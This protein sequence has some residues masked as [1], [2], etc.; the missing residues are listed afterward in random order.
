MEKLF[1]GRI[2]CI[3]FTLCEHY[4]IM[5]IFS[6]FDGMSCLQ[7]AL[8]RSGIEYDNYF[9]SETD[10][11]AIQITQKNYPLTVQL[12]D[13]SKIKGSDMPKIDLMVGGSPCQGFSFAGKHLNFNDPRSKLIFEF[14]RLYEEL[15]EINPGLKFILE[16]VRMKKEHQNVITNFF[17]IDPILINSALVSAQNRQRLYWTN[18]KTEQYG[19]FGYKRCAIPQPEDK[20]I[21][22]QDIQ[23]SEV[24]EKYNLSPAAIKRIL[25]KSP[26]INP[27]KAYAVVKNNNTSSFG[28]DRSATLI[29]VVNDRGQLRQTEKSMA[30]DANYHKGMDNHSQRS[31][32]IQLNPSKETRMGKGPGG[33][34]PLSKKD[35]KSYVLDTSANQ[36]IE[37]GQIRRLTTVECERLQTVPDN[38]TE[39]VSDSQRYKMLG[40]GFTVD[41]ICHLLKYL[42][43]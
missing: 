37:Y 38:Y 39:G 20:G 29:G 4:K 32:V 35:N 12:G 42:G 27:E 18:I 28:N 6:P 13:I 22:L 36:A 17:G 10:K 24:D 40:N 16:N 33:K 11:Y 5:N 3:K 43:T 31:M 14:F 1:T 41:V 7:I 21:L 30:V 23:E 2:N 15:K 19:L 25:R 34:G 8:N 26:K 9:A